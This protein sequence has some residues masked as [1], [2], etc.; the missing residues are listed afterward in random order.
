MGMLSQV[1]SEFRPLLVLF[2]L[3]EVKFLILKKKMAVKGRALLRLTEGKLEQMGIDEENHRHSLLE[4]ILQ[5]RI[6]DD[7]ESLT[8]IFE[9]IEKNMTAYTG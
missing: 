1:E 9:V 5:L 2:F 8:S 6:Q 3:P 4:E 7:V